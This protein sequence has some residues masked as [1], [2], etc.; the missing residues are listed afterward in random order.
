MKLRKRIAIAL[1]MVLLLSLLPQ[2][3]FAGV[4]T[5]WNDQC[6]GNP[7]SVGTYG[8]HN[9]VKQWERSGS[10]CTSKGRAGYRCSY[11]GA[12]IERETSAPGHSWGKWKTVTKA[13][14]QKQGQQTRT[15]EVCGKKETRST[16]KAAHTWGEWTVTV[17]A[18]D[19]SMGTRT[20]TCQV[21]GKEKTED[22]Y[23]DP[24]Y[25]RGDKG[26]GVRDLQEKLNAAGFDCGKVDGDF[27]KK[28][29]AAVKA[30][31]K[32][33]G[34]HEDGIAWPGVL[35]WL[36]IIEDTGKDLKQ[37]PAIPDD[38]PIGGGMFGDAIISLTAD[39]IPSKPYA[40]G[41]TI[42]TVC[43][44][45]NLTD[46]TLEIEYLDFSDEI[47]DEIVHETW[48]EQSPCL[49]EAHATQTFEVSIVVNEEDVEDQW[50][51]RYAYAGAYVYGDPGSEEEASCEIV[52]TMQ[53]AAAS[54]FVIADYSI[55]YSGVSGDTVDIPVKVFNNGDADLRI[56]GYD[57]TGVG[58]A[59]GDSD[60]LSVPTEYWS[61]F[62]AGD[63]FQAVLS[64]ILCD[65]DTL[66]AETVEGDGCTERT[67]SVI[68]EELV[69][70]EQIAD[71]DTAYIR[72]PDNTKTAALMRLE[73][74][75][76]TAQTVFMK[77]ETI[78]FKLHAYN[79]TIDTDL[80]DVRVRQLDEKPNVISTF[81]AE[82]LEKADAIGFNDSHTFS[83]EEA[84]A[85]TVT[86]TWD[87]TAVDEA[88][89]PV[90]AKPISLSYTVYDDD[91][92]WIPPE[93]GTVEVV[94]AEASVRPNPKGYTTG[95]VVKYEITVTNNTFDYIVSLQVTDPLK[96]ENEDA[97]VAVIP[98]LASGESVTVKYEHTV[99]AEE[100]AAGSILNTATVFWYI[101]GNVLPTTAVSNEVEVPT[102]LRKQPPVT[103]S[104][105]K[106]PVCC[107]RTLTAMGTGT[108]EYTLDYCA[109]HEPVRDKVDALVRGART[110]R[111]KLDAWEQA[112]LIWTDELNEEYDKL[113]AGRPDAEK[114]VILN[115]KALFF[116]SLSSRREELN[117]LYASDPATPAMLI[118]EQ[119][120]NR[121]ADLCYERHM[122]PANRSDSVTGSYGTLALG[123]PAAQCGREV[124]PTDKG[125][126][127]TE[128]LCA[129]HRETELTGLETVEK[130]QDKVGAW[131]TVKL[132][133]LNQL[134][135]L[136]NRI[137]LASDA[138]TQRAIGTERVTYGQWLTE[139]EK[140][141]N[142]LYPNQPEIVAE[143]L[144]M[145]IRARVLDLCPLDRSVK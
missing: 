110:D 129:E 80:Y 134:D 8:N 22:Y 81:S 132:M 127:Y 6:R 135:A 84:A 140:E 144:A 1:A 87:C 48:M 36:G 24:T 23:P 32:A 77:G 15:C 102:Y 88:G 5:G 47:N 101:R 60:S 119:L 3:V 92:R 111:E 16:D 52:F 91:Y 4:G 100:A 18:T 31:E 62:P 9:W 30:I 73:V 128:N 70:K 95:D 64:A 13:T 51:L 141:L 130:A 108:E 12:S 69:T 109:E 39:L 138:E 38:N 45:T 133:W 98:G 20:H 74:I 85:G 53:K 123:A 125:A 61:L 49:L 65:D 136:I 86:L 26:D 37:A 11:C 96:G 116:S 21:C 33:N 117:A 46:N 35:K 57:V 143:V 124:N 105:K 139:R 103:P 137:Y 41:D 121:T 25:K 113:L 145:T 97:I 42:T 93:E 112:I 76:D 27:G 126:Q 83:A 118:S 82:K 54:I 75:P 115:E 50:G 72:M 79:D 44:L 56:Y 104:P 43:H 142:I 90:S 2:A 114:A 89:N 34:V 28:T 106:G 107:V 66:F 10:D 14:C 71:W 55:Q 99:T 122:A 131:R 78:N 120:M 63:A 19:F 94:K 40:V 58:G 59:S 68:A 7:N 29:E 67:A 17:P